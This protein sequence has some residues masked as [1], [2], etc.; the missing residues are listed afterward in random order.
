MIVGLLSVECPLPFQVTSWLMLLLLKLL[1]ATLSTAD[2][3]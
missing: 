1:P 3:D 2:S